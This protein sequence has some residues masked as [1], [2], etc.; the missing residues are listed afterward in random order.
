MSTVYISNGLCPPYDEGCK[1]FARELA[2]YIHDEGKGISVSNYYE[3]ASLGIYKIPFSKKIIGWRLIAFV[4]KSGCEHIILLPQSPLTFWAFLKAFLLKT[5]T[6]RPVSII[7]LQPWTYNQWQKFLLRGMRSV[8]PWVQSRRNQAY[9]TGLGFDAGF[10][11]AGVDEHTSAA[12]KPLYIWWNKIDSLEYQ[13]I[14][15]ISYIMNI[16]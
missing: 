6:G 13:R 12:W 10:L 14:F 9:L 3:D 5:L 15:S 8:R 11:P 16:K 1:I 4:R 7:G 2:R